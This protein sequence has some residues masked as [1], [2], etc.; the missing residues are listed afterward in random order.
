MQNF[1]RS[2]FISMKPRTV[3]LRKCLVKTLALA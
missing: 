3:D 1:W 2:Q